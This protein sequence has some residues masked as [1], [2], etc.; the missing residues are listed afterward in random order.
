MNKTI[1]KIVTRTAIFATKAHG[2]LLN[3]AFIAAWKLLDAL[4]KQPRIKIPKAK[5]IIAI[6]LI[7]KGILFFI[8]IS[9]SLF[10]NWFM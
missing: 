6:I 2:H 10:W 1:N 5:S 9:K 7:P 4:K 8:F 3:K